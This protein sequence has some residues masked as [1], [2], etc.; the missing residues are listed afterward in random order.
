[1]VSIHPPKR[2][3]AV[4][5]GSGAQGRQVIERPLTLGP[6]GLFGIVTEIPGKSTGPVIVFL[7]VATEH[8]VGPARLWTEMAREWATHGLRSLRV[9]MSSIGESP[10]RPGQPDFVIRLPVNFE[11]VKEIA[12]AA[13]PD[14]PSDVVLVG[15]CSSAYQSLDSALQIH[16]RGVIALNPVLTFQP[17][18]ILMGGTMDQ[19]RR[20]ALARGSVIEQFSGEGR[21]SVLRKRFPNLGWRIRTLMAFNKR[22]SLWLKDLIGSG[23]SLM[24]ICGDRESRPFNQD[25]SAR[26][27]EKMKSTG[28]LSYEYIPGLDHGLLIAAHRDRIRKHVT[29]YVIDRFAKPQSSEEHRLHKP[30]A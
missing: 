22:P 25:V 23:T 20:V 4:A 24:L 7:N 6:T 9:D 1:M 19:R 28:K 26:T 11:D 10:T 2:G 14:D 12:A 13:S 3:E 8:H 15:L 21:L 30:G 5:V 18:E 27:F 16:P 17:P 29:D